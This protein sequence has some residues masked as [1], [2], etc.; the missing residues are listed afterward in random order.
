MRQL[1]E[2][3]LAGADGSAL[4]GAAGAAREVFELAAARGPVEPTAD[5]SFASL[6]GLYWM[7]INVTGD[8]PLVMAIDDVHWCDDASLRFLAYLVRRLEGLPVLLILTLRPSRR[9]KFSPLS[10]IMR[11]PLTVSM[12]PGA[13]SG[14]AAGELV[15]ARLGENADEAF[16]AACHNATGGNPLLLQELLKT[17]EG[18][19]FDLTPMSPPS[20]ISALA[21][22]RVRSPPP[23]RLSEGVVSARARRRCSATTRIFPRWRRSDVDVE[24]AGAAVACWSVEV[25]RPGPS[26]GSFIRSSAPRS[27][28]TCP[29]WT[30]ART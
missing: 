22:H 17:L 30:G 9:R 12:D 20:R 16:S 2:Q 21:L 25:L 6:H 15:R 24:A 7:T 4:D 8:A 26:L 13:L 10:E 1:F 11:D 29:W 23:V 5:P 14:A 27:T 3:S 18:E 19:G 28:T